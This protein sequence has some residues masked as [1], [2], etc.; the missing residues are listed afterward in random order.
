MKEN[1]HKKMGSIKPRRRKDK[2]LENSTE[3]QAIREQH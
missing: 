3:R 2:Q 1:N